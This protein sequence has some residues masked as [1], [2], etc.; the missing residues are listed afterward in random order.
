MKVKLIVF[1]KDGRTLSGT[2]SHL[3]ALARLAFARDLPNYAGFD[4]VGAEGN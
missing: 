2:Y 3:A 1:L 4:I